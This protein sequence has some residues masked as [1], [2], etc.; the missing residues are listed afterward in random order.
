MFCMITSMVFARSFY[1]ATYHH[2][3]GQDC[4]ISRHMRDIVITL[5]IN[6]KKVFDTIDHRYSENCILM[7]SKW[8]KSYLTAR[9]QY[10]VFDGE[11]SETHSVKSGVRPRSILGS[12][13]F[14]S[15]VNDI[16]NVSPLLIPCVLQSFLSY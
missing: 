15:L 1:S 13:L 3:S 10:V 4:E 6:L 16:C 11:A 7:E 14:I 8:F 12:L 5:F 9:S 2:S